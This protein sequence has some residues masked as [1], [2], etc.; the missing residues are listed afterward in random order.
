MSDQDHPL[1]AAVAPIA[2]MIGGE[3]IPAADIEDGDLQLEWEGVVVGGFRIAPMQT[4]LDRIVAAVEH[5]LGAA[6]PNLDRIQKQ[7]A[8]RLLDEKGAFLLRKSIEDVADAMGVSR[9][10]IYNYLNTVR[11]G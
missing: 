4:A 9:I 6:L 2:A 1:L 10:T 11:T 8:I 5:E 7:K 3:V